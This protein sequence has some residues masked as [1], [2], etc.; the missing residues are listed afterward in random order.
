MSFLF[1]FFFFSSQIQPSFSK[2]EKSSAQPL[3]SLGFVGDSLVKNLVG[4]SL[5]SERVPTGARETVTV[6]LP[7]V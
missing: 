3:A 2:S 7:D 4:H 6:A 5:K 1:S